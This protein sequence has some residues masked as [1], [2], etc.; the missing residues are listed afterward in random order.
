M[1]QSCRI[2]RQCLQQMEERGLL[3]DPNINGM[4]R[5]TVRPPAGEIY[6]RTETPRGELGYHIISDGSPT[7]FRVKVRAP[8]FCA[9]SG[10]HVVS[11]GHLVADIIVILGSIDIVLGEVDR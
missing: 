9:L 1:R 3:E 4:R 6:H 11:R 7:P 2:L 8:S 5:G 10:M